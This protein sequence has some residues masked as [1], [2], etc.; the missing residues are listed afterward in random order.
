MDPRLRAAVDANLGWYETLSAAHGLRFELRDGLWIALGR[1]PRLHSDV[2][3]VEPDATP[4]SVDDA[5]AGRDGWG[6]KDSFATI[7]PSG[8]GVRLLFGATW[9]HRAPPGEPA[10]TT[11]Q[12]TRL[13]T[14]A[15]LAAW[16]GHAGTEGVVL[17][18]LLERSGFAV[19]ER[20][21]EHGVTAGAIARLGA[22]VVELS[23]VHGVDGAPIDWDELAVEVAA[24]FPGRPQVGYESGQDLDWAVAAGFE[25]VGE[26]RIW[27]A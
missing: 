9:L 5:L 4:A 14:D 6:F 27:V 8:P 17:P 13:R 1:P 21:T 19:L 7:E 3:T 22:G 25:P 20:R 15:E 2:M 11:G 16:N 23:N 12:W 26:L 10:T 18:S 24:L